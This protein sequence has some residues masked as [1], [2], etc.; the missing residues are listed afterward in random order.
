MVVC[1]CFGVDEINVI[2]FVESVDFMVGAVVEVAWDKTGTLVGCVV[3][4]VVTGDWVVCRMVA[5][6]WVRRCVEEV[7]R[8]VLDAVRVD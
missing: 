6:G 2:C 8:V 7:S 3:C 1:I 5:C 4:L